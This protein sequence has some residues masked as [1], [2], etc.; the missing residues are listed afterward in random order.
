MNICSYCALKKAR[1][2]A[3]VD[4][5]EVTVLNDTSWIVGG[6]NIYVHPP[7]VVIHDLPGGEDGERA[8]YRWSWFKQIEDHCTC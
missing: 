3:E 2:K 8:V 5:K 7:S 1:K 6:V 4:K